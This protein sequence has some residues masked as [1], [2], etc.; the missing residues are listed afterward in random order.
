MQSQHAS[1]VQ[2]EQNSSSTTLKHST[3][4]ALEDIWDIP[5]CEG[6]GFGNTSCLILCCLSVATLHVC[7]LCPCLVPDASGF[8]LDLQNV[9]STVSCTR[10]IMMETRC[11]RF[12]TLLY[13]F[14][15]D[16][17]ETRNLL[18]SADFVR[19]GYRGCDGPQAQT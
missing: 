6:L 16:C 10:L 11:V 8:G 12:H 15:R 9:L 7:V 13:M 17:I 14:Q 19:A 3:K 2:C 5:T 4:V 18:C 1:V